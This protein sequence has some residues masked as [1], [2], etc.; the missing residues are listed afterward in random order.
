L[1]DPAPSSSSAAKRRR[2][3]ITVSEVVGIAAVIIA[4]LSFWDSHRERVRQDRAAAAAAH[5]TPAD[6]VFALRG[7]ADP[8]GGRIQLRTVSDSQIIQ[9]QTFVFPTE[10]REQPVHTTG[11]ADIEAAWFAGGLKKAAP[12]AGRGSDDDQALPVVITTT[13][14]VDGRLGRASGVYT[15]GYRLKPR[16]PFGASVELRGLALRAGGHGDPRAL[17]EQAWASEN[18]PARS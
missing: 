13:Y 6:P 9:E 18:P 17:V 2:A 7:E 1:S 11:G 12:K 8:N 10:V 15:I 5:Q 16:F 4:A 14:T 3:W